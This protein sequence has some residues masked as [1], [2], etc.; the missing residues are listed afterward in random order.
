MRISSLH[1]SPPAHNTHNP[2]NSRPDVG[3]TA[4]ARGDARATGARRPPLLGGSLKERGGEGADSRLQGRLTYVI[5]TL[6]VVAFT[7]LVLGSFWLVVASVPTL[8]PAIG[9]SVPPSTATSL[10]G[11]VSSYRGVFLFYAMAFCLMA[12]LA[13]V[14]PAVASTAISGE[15]EEGRSTCCSP[16]AGT[17]LDHLRQAGG[18]GRLHAAGGPDGGAGLRDGLDVRRRAASR[19]R[20]DGAVAGVR[21]V[22]VRGDR[23]ILLLAG[24]HVGCGRAVRLRAGLPH[25][26]RAPWPPT[27]SAPRC[28]W[29]RRSA[30]CWR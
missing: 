12:A 16:A 15:R 3:R 17:P 24:T 6:M 11:L 8:V 18:V 20:A 23:A 27:S 13:V 7:G 2:Q 21:A 25:R 29:N 30:R 10:P 5:L 9:S 26:H 22:A 28:R 19:R 14:A 4:C 1:A